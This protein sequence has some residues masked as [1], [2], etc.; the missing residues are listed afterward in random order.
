MGSATNGHAASGRG[1]L[2]LIFLACLAAPAL[3]QDELAAKIDAVLA[4]GRLA[5]AK[6]GVCVIATQSGRVL[7]RR[8]AMTPL[9]P[10]SNQKIVAAA[11]ALRELGLDYEF[12]TR[13]FAVGG[14]DAGGVLQ[15][16][17]ILQGGGDPSVGSPAMGEKPL[18]QFERWAAVLTKQGITKVVG[19]LVL[20]DSFFDRKHVHPDWPDDQLWRHYCA[21]VGALAFQDNCLTVNVTP[22]KKAG[23]KAVVR[24]SPACAL[25]SAAVSC[26]TSAKRH[27]VWLERKP[28]SN[29]VRVGGN[30]RSS[31]SGYSGIVTVPDPAIF[32]GQSFAGVL[33]K[34]G[35]KLGGEVRLVTDEDRRSRKGW[36]LVAE[37]RTPLKDVLRVMLRESQNMYAEAVVKTVG[38]ERGEG[39]SWESGL[40]GAAEMIE[41]LHF[42]ADEF[43]LA[44]GSGMSRENRLPPA[45]LCA[46][47][48]EMDREKY[49]QALAE[50]LAA[51]GDPGTLEKRFGESQYCDRLR[52]KTG[53]IYRVGAL[54]GYAQTKSGIRVA[55]CILINN[56]RNRGG[57]W[58]MKQIEDRIAR[59][60]I[61]CAE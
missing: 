39:G 52:A 56:F 17:L 60:I 21:P 18:E 32:A 6:V 45:L 55:F 50:L 33:R 49:G 4:D 41:A 20:D 25:L 15:G 48:L 59:A 3:A 8:N 35:M 58:A 24:F 22:G 34:K 61:D 42:R 11:A 43:A 23:Q 26:E 19:D 9:I 31:S 40:D 30:I 27:A 28:G 38:A 1:P 57:N 44:D 36:R 46:V 12:K 29:L 14:I 13:L 37:R 7:Y 47:L 54:S 53:Y 51:P 16:D 2:C 5:G 10:A